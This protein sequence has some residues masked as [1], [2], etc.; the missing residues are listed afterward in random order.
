NP[1]HYRRGW[2]CT[3]TIGTLGAAA[4]SA[5][6]L[7]LDADATAHALALAAS[8]ASGLKANF[9]TMTKPFH[10]GLAARNGVQAAQLAARGFTASDAAL[11][12]TQGFVF[13]FDG[14]RRDVLP[15]VTDLG[16]R[17]EISETGPS[18]KLYPSCAAT[19]PMLDMLLDMKRR[20][21]FGADDVEPIE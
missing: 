15:F 1:S 21:G 19:H 3:S 11:D 7:R 18:V 9:G 4:A 6:V 16:R 2:H 17:W 14:E 10:A 8:H 13:A 12:G 20:A 5:R